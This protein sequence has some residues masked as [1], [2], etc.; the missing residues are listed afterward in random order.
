[1]QPHIKLGYM[2]T[3]LI[4]LL[5]IGTIFFNQ[6][7]GWS[8]VDSFYFST[9]T[10]TTIGFG[11][12]TP[13]TNTSKMFTS[14]YAIFGIGA[15]LYILST[16]IGTYWFRQRKRFDKLITLLHKIHFHRAKINIKEEMEK[17]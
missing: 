5:S 16:V 17:K 13:T 3:I 14:F 2:V 10:L 11:D 1:M 9:T 12:L 15:M 6:V 8:Y 4:I 7:E